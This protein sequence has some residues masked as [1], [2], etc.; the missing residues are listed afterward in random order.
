M[1][2]TE[3]ERNARDND[4]VLIAVNHSGEN[5]LCGPIVS[6]S[7][8]LDYNLIDEKLIEEIVT[9]G[10]L[11]KECYASITK[12]IKAFST[13]T[14]SA[15]KLNSIMS[16]PLALHMADYNSLMGAVF[17][18]FKVFGKD[19]DVVQTK[20]PIKEVTKNK[21]LPIYK[22]E[23][24]KTQYVIRESWTQFDNLIPNTEIKVEQEDSFS[25]LFAKAVSETIIQKELKAASEK[26]PNYD[27]SANVLS[28][29]QKAILAASGMTE[30][31]RAFLPDFSGF[32]FSPRIML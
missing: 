10:V 31:H 13:Y 25:L 15:A 24:S 20:L 2:L 12:A 22:N 21:E 11:S 3:D 16:I 30:F 7:L 27:F 17:E 14:L 23:K 32:A 6:C 29:S 1:M 8:V 4:S 18:V 5:N 26:Y 19:P 9:R 28:D